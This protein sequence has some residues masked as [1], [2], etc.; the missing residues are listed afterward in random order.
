MRFNGLAHRLRS[1]AWLPVFLAVAGLVIYLRYFSPVL[2][3]SQRVEQGGVVAE[4]FGTGTLEARVK[5]S[6]GP[7]ISGKI[8]QVL[9]DQ[10]DSVKAG[11]LLFQLEDKDFNEQVAISKANLEAARAAVDRLM[12]DKRRALAVFEQSQKSQARYVKLLERKAVSQEDVD[13]ANEALAV[14]VADVARAEAG[15]AEGQKN[16]VAAEKTLQFHEAR[17]KDTRIAAPFDGLIVKR[18]HEPGDIV[19]PGSSALSL[20]SLNEMWV[21][22]WVDETEMSRLAPGQ[23]ARVK[24]RS[25]PVRQYPAKVTRLGREADRETREFVVDVQVLNLPQNWA[26]GQRADVQ[27]ELGRKEGV[28]VIPSR[29]VLRKEGVAGVFVNSGGRARWREIQL[30]MEGLETLE[31]VAGL[32]VHE[33][34]V[35]PAPGVAPLT[36][37]RRI[38]SK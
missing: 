29:F 26:V 33:L 38:H 37:G 25:E 5:A 23:L 17:L 11:D 22:A 32:A 14:A 28:L 16:L 8:S 35:M 27:I 24:F 18:S 1:L 12:A 31:V 15:I 13:K 9:V 30:G 2:V 10:G 3:E 7:K 36:D 19:V 21:S 20:I 34:I 6:I 4:V